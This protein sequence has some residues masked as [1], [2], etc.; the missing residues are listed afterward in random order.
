METRILV[1]VFVNT[2]KANVIWEKILVEWMNKFA[3]VSHIVHVDQGCE[4]V[5]NGF[6]N[7]CMSLCIYLKEASVK[8]IYSLGIGERYYGPM[9]KNLYIYKMKEEIP[10]LDDEIALK[11]AIRAINDCLGP[12]GLVP[13]LLV[14]R[15]LPRIPSES[16]TN[17]S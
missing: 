13:S 7:Y 11:M 5:S 4:L 17:V 12:E 14:I 9:K 2:R 1:A 3:G 6:K 10:H 8:S 16:D 15:M